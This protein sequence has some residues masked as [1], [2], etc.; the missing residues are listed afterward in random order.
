MFDTVDLDPVA[1]SL[2]YIHLIQEHPGLES[3][4][5]DVRFPLPGL[6]VENGEHADVPH[7]GRDTK[8]GDV[9]KLQF[10]SRSAVHLEKN[11][12]TAGGATG[13]SVHVRHTKIAEMGI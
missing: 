3:N 5:D 11:S 8:V 4:V 9:V 12:C 10:V 2:D 1:A 13:R 6:D 7:P